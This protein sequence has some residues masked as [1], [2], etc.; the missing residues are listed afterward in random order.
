M[1]R[2][3][4]KT[5]RYTRAPLG[6]WRRAFCWLPFHHKESGWRLP[7]LCDGNEIAASICT[8]LIVPFGSARFFNFSVVQRWTTEKL[9]MSICTLLI[10]HF[11]SARFSAFRDG[12]V[13]AS[14]GCRACWRGGW[15]H[16]WRGIY[17]HETGHNEIGQAAVGGPR[18]QQRVETADACKGDG[19]GKKLLSR[20]GAHY[21]RNTGLLSRDATH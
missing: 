20:F 12:R 7:W 1:A 16:T 19:T 5:A 17:R 18:K 15:N 8:L 6:L 9:N 2:C 10:V 11:G 4:T 13:A 3:C 14:L 21:V